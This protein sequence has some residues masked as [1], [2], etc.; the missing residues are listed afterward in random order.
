MN[1]ARAA[2]RYW[3]GR[4]VGAFSRPRAWSGL[5][6]DRILA[7][8]P[9]HVLEFGCNVG[10][11]LAAIRTRDPSVELRGI[12]INARAVAV[13]RASGLALTVGDER[14]LARFR[15]GEFD[16]AFTSSVIDH[17]PEPTL[18]LMQLDRVARVL[19]LLEPWLGYEGKVEW[20]RP[21]ER[22]NPFLY[23]WDYAARLPGR[24]VTSDPMPIRPEGAGP[25]YRLHVA[26]PCD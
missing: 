17:I 1:E 16:V 3:A 20:V 7:E 19:I 6:A 11:H 14:S 2:S 4:K 5:L 13:G 21:G 22:A 24:V 26:R 23:S 12:D 15:D 25:W 8:H 10:R 9:R 18:A